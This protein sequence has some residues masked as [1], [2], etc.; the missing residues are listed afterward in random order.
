MELDEPVG[1]GDGTAKGNKIFDCLP[2]YGGFF[3][4]KNITVGNFPVKDLMDESDEDEPP[5]P[6]D[7]EM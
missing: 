3:R 1:K 4:G 6:D 5:L 2:K 7:D